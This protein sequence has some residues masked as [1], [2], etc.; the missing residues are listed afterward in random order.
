MIEINHYG[1]RSVG[2]M[3]QINYYG[4]ISVGYMIEIN[5]YDL[6][7]AKFMIKT[8]CYGL[9]SVGCMK[10]INCYG[11]GS[12]R[13]MKEINC[14]CLGSVVCMIEINCWPEVGWLY[15][16]IFFFGHSGYLK[17]ACIRILPPGSFAP[18]ILINIQQI[19]QNVH[20]SYCVKHGTDN[21]SCREQ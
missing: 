1:L 13:Q 10:E 7:S 2:H 19:R 21:K 15:E 6:R 18:A 16:T 5:C 11:L 4:Q 20:S 17:P 8:N 14:Y 12:V 3:I 9:G